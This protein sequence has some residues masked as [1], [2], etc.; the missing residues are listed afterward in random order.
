MNVTDEVVYHQP[1]TEEERAGV[2]KACALRLNFEM[3]MLLDRMTN[4]VDT[5]Y[6]ALPERLYLLDGDGTIRWRSDPGPWGFDVDGWGKA[7]QEL[8]RRD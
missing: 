2:A 3:P 1:K 4:E 6:S 7:I 8:A 5:A